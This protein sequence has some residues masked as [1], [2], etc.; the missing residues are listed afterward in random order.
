MASEDETGPISSFDQQIL[1]N[2][3]RYAPRFLETRQLFE[4]GEQVGLGSFPVCHTTEKMIGR[5]VRMELFEGQTHY[6]RPESFWEERTLLERGEQD[7]VVITPNLSFPHPELASIYDRSCPENGFVFIPDLVLDGI[8]GHELVHWKL[9]HGRMPKEVLKVI[10]G[11]RERFN[12][13]IGENTDWVDH[14]IHAEID[15]IT[16]LL[17][18]R[19]Q[20]VAALEYSIEGQIRNKDLDKK[21]L[22]GLLLRRRA[23]L[24]YCS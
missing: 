1:D 4:V 5:L 6:Y 13:D 11:R 18:L 3:R 14:T 9:E 19:T 2:L 17:G 10:K 22:Q 24:E 12:Y 20:I 16:G 21:G 8:A 23:V 15:I 7:R